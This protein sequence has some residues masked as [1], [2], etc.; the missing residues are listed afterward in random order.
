MNFLYKNSFK[1]LYFEGST[2]VFI[3][4]YLFVFIFS[5]CIK[6]HFTF[7]APQYSTFNC[8][9]LSQQIICIVQPFVSEFRAILTTGRNQSL[10]FSSSSESMHI[11]IFFTVSLISRCKWKT[12]YFPLLFNRK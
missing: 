6:T 8:T 1:K 7:L 10:H 2:I 9:K 12:F 4:V 3:F 5:N 11:I